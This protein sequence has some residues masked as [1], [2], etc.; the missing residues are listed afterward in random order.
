MSDIKIICGNIIEKDNQFLLVKETK[1]VAKNLYNIPSGKLENNES[2]IE[3]AIREAK[4]ETGLDIMPKHLIGIYQK[5][6]SKTGAN[7]VFFI[8]HSIIKG[9]EITPSLEHP[10]VKFFSYDEIIMLEKKHFLRSPHIL[11]ALDAYRRKD[12]KDISHLS[13]VNDY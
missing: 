4:E 11:L 9:G 10:E 8:F 1:E 3:G 5:P 6:K 2:I 12:F 7:L 13:I